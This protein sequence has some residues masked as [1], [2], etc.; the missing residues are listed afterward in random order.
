M[1]KLIILAISLVLGGNAFSQ[2]SVSGGGTF[3]KWQDGGTSFRAGFYVGVACTLQ[4][5]S[6]P[7]LASGGLLFLNR[8]VCLDGGTDASHGGEY[9]FRTSLYS[10]HVP[11]EF[12]FK[13][14]YPHSKILAVPKVGVF[15]DLGLFGDISQSPEVSHL[16]GYEHVKDG[17]FDNLNPYTGLAGLEYGGIK[18]FD[19]FDWGV[20]AGLD[21]FLHKGL[22]LSFVY[23]HSFLEVFNPDAD[24]YNSKFSSFSLGVGYLFPKG[25]RVDKVVPLV[26]L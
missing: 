16:G 13:R 20:R 24:V 2:V 4:S 23:E 10:F 15:A 3:S 7:L 12:G 22:F 14:Y 26:E 25:E 18:N 11:V 21:L 5:D 6:S 9:A 8:G 1:N 17:K 19:R